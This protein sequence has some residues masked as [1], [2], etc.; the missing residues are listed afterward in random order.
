M[1]ASGD[2]DLLI[3]KTPVEAINKSETVLVFITKSLHHTIL[4]H[5][6]TQ[7]R[8]S[9]STEIPEHWHRY[10]N[11]HVILSC[12]TTLKLFGI[13]NTI[14]L[15]P[16]KDID[17]FCQQAQVLENSKSNPAQIVAAVEK[18]QICF[19]KGKS[20][21]TLD[22]LRSSRFQEKVATNIAFVQPKD[23]PLTP[24]AAQCHSF[25]VFQ[26]VLDWKGHKLN[27]FERGW[28]MTDGRMTPV[29]SD[30]NAASEYIIKLVRCICEVDCF[31]W[32]CGFRST[33][34][35]RTVACSECRG[36]CAYGHKTKD[37]TNQQMM[38]TDVSE[39]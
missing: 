23:P 7:E 19:Y 34:L 17:V 38:I 2:I 16:L 6:R 28:K 15:T 24:A 11:S 33:G 32:R 5:V 20:T 27:P 14:G 31:K 21:D 3:A 35:E 29:H 4:L 18:A 10:R 30:Q 37:D 22:S 39:D 1:S 25:Q 26:Q 8:F 12:D 13:G 36:I 9:T